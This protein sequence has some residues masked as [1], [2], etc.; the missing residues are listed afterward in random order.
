[1]L[2]DRHGKSMSGHS[3]FLYI[4]VYSIYT[5]VNNNVQCRSQK[6]AIIKINLPDVIFFF[7]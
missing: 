6:L 1:M 5:H 3:F 7:R 4:L 2:Y